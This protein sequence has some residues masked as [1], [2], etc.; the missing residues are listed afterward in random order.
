MER[1][2][3]KNSCLPTLCW[4]EYKNARR[5]SCVIYKQTECFECVILLV[6]LERCYFNVI[7]IY[8]HKQYDHLLPWAPYYSTQPLKLYWRPEWC[9]GSKKD[10]IHCPLNLFKSIQ[11]TQTAPP[12]LGSISLLTTLEEDFSFTRGQAGPRNPREHIV[13]CPEN[14]FKSAQQPQ[15]TPLTPGLQL[16]WSTTSKEDICFTRV[17][18]RFREPRSITSKQTS[19]LPENRLDLETKALATVLEARLVLTPRP[20]QI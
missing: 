12:T 20:N 17:Q 19:A 18:A 16:S 15:T 5:L 3:R 14:F 2:Y 10:I 11:Q 7:W 8:F 1:I 9:Y 4:R 13:H 6:Y